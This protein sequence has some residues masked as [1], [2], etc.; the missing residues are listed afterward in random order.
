MDRMKPIAFLGTI[1]AL[2][3]LEWASPYLHRLSWGVPF[4]P[5]A[6]TALVRS[7]DVL[8]FLTLF[9]VLCVPISTAGLKR[10]ATGILVG[11]AVSLVLGGGFF[12]FT[13]FVRLLWKIDLTALLGSGVRVR[14]VGSLVVLCLVGPFTEELFFRGLCYTLIKTNTA[15]WFAVIS[16]T[17]LFGASHL[18][19]GATATGVVVPLCGGVVLALLYELTGSL[20]TPF[21][22][23]AMANFIL[24]TRII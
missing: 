13:L 2:V 23:H 16:S 19:G 20:F 10:P 9:R 17:V 18:L 4:S 24:F 1:A 11:L 3:A 21:A 5:L 8:L 7:M 22:L 14:G 12:L 6:W 15:V